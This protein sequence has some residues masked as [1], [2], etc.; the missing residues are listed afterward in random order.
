[1]HSVLIYLTELFITDKL[2]QLIY[3]VFLKPVPQSTN[4]AVSL[5]RATMY[6]LI[7]LLDQT[8]YQWPLLLKWFN[9]NPSM[10]K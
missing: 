7:I 6:C 4:S 8:G 10:D 5:I 1:M 3:S 2:H 9:F